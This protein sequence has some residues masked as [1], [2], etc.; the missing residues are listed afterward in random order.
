MARKEKKLYT[1]EIDRSYITRVIVRADTP[2]EAQLKAIDGKWIKSKRVENE[3]PFQLVSK[4][5][6]TSFVEA[7]PLTV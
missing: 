7:S 5:Q 3:E 1:L 6:L 2:E 4:P